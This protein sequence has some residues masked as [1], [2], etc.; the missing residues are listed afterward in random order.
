MRGNRYR[1]GS[2]RY[3][4]SAQD[5]AHQDVAGQQVTLDR[6][7]HE[8]P[9]K[10]AG[11]VRGAALFLAEGPRTVFGMKDCQ[12]LARG[13]RVKEEDGNHLARGQGCTKYTSISKFDEKNLVLH[14]IL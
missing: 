13:Q 12:G 1:D 6:G 2:R 8:K 10:R 4:F 3:R 5:F 14:H 9:Q 7:R 11:R